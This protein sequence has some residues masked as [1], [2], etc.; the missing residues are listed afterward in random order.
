LGV[1]PTVWQGGSHQAAFIK[2]RQL[3][4]PIPN[5]SNIYAL[6]K[7]RN[8]SAEIFV[9]CRDFLAPKF[10]DPKFLDPKHVF[11]D[12]SSSIPSGSG[13]LEKGTSANNAQMNVFQPDKK[14]RK[15]E[16]YA[17]GDYTLF[18]KVPASE[19]V[20][21]QDPIM[22][23]GTANQI[24]FETEEEKGW[25]AN[26]IMTED[27]KANCADLKVLGKGDFK[28]LLRWRTTLRE[29]VRFSRST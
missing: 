29:E 24:A 17:D 21:A 9:V 26:E 7:C 10:I 28:A 16:G 4:I 1:Q 8:V 14:R 12:L 19:F 18:H 22:V 6:Q 27:I 11:K 13:Q 5:L 20:R 3:V 25:L 2:V 15:R 23:L